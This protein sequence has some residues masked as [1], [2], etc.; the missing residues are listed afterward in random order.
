[1]LQG[2]RDAAS[3]SLL[4][5]IALLLAMAVGPLPSPAAAVITGE[6]TGGVCDYDSSVVECADVDGVF[7]HEGGPTQ[8]L[9][10]EDGTVPP[11]A[12]GNAATCDYDAHVAARAEDGR[13][14]RPE[15]AL[16]Q[17]LTGSEA[18]AVL[19]V[20]VDDAATTPLSL[21][22][23]PEALTATQRGRYLLDNWHPATFPN[24]TQSVNYHLARHGNG[25]TAFEYTRDAQNFFSQNRGL[26]T[27]VTLRDGTAGLRIQTKVPVPGGG[28]RNVGGY[29]TTDGRLVTFWD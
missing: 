9:H 24:R 5:V 16:S 15:G 8:V 10:R 14:V 12:V 11:A 3:R 29:W 27:Q 26:A 21:R 7:A 18:T 4:L 6:R 28:T 1:M 2:G 13:A 17:A 23:A 25:R 19:V 22:R 20:A